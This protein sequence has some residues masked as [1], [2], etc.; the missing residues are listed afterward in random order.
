VDHL[1]R[2]LKKEFQLERLIL[3]T[4]A[5][6]AIAITLLAI[7]LKVPVLHDVP[8]GANMDALLGEQLGMMTPKFIGFF[9]SF[10]VIAQF[11]TGHHRLFGYLEDYNAKLIWTNMFYL[12]SVVL[13]P[14]STSFYTE[15]FNEGLKVPL[16][17]YL[18]NI[19]FLAAMNTRLWYIVSHE[20]NKLSKLQEHSTFVRFFI[21]RSLLVTIVFTV[22]FLLS[23]LSQ[24]VGVAVLSLM[25]LWGFFVRTYFKRR[26][27]F[28]LKAIH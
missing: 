16:A 4:D 5:V 21:A 9:V 24:I 25:P 18:L 17:V 6:F 20:P 27:G 10:V 19:L 14:F 2:E 28:D 12:M 26:H 13:L 8:K 11:W 23:F 15:Y 3:F 22:A 7:E 1:Q